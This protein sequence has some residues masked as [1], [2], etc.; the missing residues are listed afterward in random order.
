[1]GPAE[2]SWQTTFHTDRNEKTLLHDKDWEEEV[3]LNVLGLFE[4][5]MR[6]ENKRS[7]TN[8]KINLMV[9]EINPH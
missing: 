3:A 8:K 9:I 4:K 1:M 2:E 5:W 6:A 7:W